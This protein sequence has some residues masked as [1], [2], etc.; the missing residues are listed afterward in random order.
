LRAFGSYAAGLYLPTADMDLVYLRRDFRPGRAL[1]RPET[2]DLLFSIS[3]FLR[4][5]RIAKP[6]SITVISGAKVPIIKFVDRASNLKVDLS[7]DNDSGVVAIDTFLQWKELYPAMPIIVAIVKQYLMVRGLND[8]ATGGMGGFSTICLVTSLLQLLPASSH[9]INLGEVLV[10]FFNLYGNLFDRNSVVIRLDPPAY[11]DKKAY[12]PHIFNDKDGR[13]TIIDPNRPDNNISGGTRL[14]SDILRCFSSAH[15]ALLQR[16]N[17]HEQRDKNSPTSSF[18][19]CLV[20]G[21]F[22][23]FET[24]RQA[25]YDLGLSLNLIRPSPSPKPSKGA[26][27]ALIDLNGGPRTVNGSESGLS[28]PSSTV[29][30]SEPKDLTKSEKRAARLKKLRPELAA[31]VGNTISA[32]EAMKVGGYKT[33][34]AMNNDLTVKE[35]ALAKLAAKKKK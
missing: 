14:I 11:L 10:E 35:G 19:G 16:L 20:G 4:D 8:V 30:A 33:R 13:L 32:T 29:P 5:N 34:E 18:L 27:E 15:R 23:Q 7:F 1:S 31:S 2:K 12:M 22:T 17:A 26:K 25:L 6:T 9:P 3:R 24:Q 28:L 21:N